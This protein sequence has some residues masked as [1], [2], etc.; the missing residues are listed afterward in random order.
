MSIITS[1]IGISIDT[2]IE[3]TIPASS[4]LDINTHPYDEF[5]ALKYDIR[6]YNNTEGKRKIFQVRA[7]KQTT[8]EVKDTIDGNLGDSLDVDTQVIKSGSDMIL[9]M[10]NQES[11]DVSVRAVKSII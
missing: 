3:K 5:S 1:A 11:F 6:L 7:I 2:I 10:T 8:G 4:S 9:R